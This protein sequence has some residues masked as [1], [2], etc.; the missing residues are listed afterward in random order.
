[1]GLGVMCYFL[2]LASQ[3][4]VENVAAIGASGDPDDEWR[5]SDDGDD[6]SSSDSENED[7]DSESES[8]RKSRGR[9]GV[10][11][12]EDLY[13]VEEREGEEEVE[14][15]PGRCWP[16]TRGRYKPMQPCVVADFSRNKC[17]ACVELKIA[18]VDEDPKGKRPKK[19]VREAAVKKTPARRSVSRARV[20]EE[21]VEGRPGDLVEELRGLRADLARSP[22]GHLR[23]MSWNSGGS[24][25]SWGTHHCYHRNS[26]S[27][28]L[29]TFNKSHSLLQA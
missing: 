29:Y 4:T 18:C 6:S 28:T 21:V 24:F 9:R 8:L 7:Q 10:K 11:S 19:M 20:E 3:T 25:I 13:T 1:M 2:R 26:H 23:S 12:F 5:P 16:C 17:W 27:L 14:R 22:A 15:R